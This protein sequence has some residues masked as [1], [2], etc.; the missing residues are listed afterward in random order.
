MSKRKIIFI[1]TALFAS[2]T[3]SAKND[4]NDLIY[5]IEEELILSEDPIIP[6]EIRINDPVWAS[7]PT[8]KDI[9]KESIKNVKRALDPKHLKNKSYSN[10]KKTLLKNSRM[11]KPIIIRNLYSDDINVDIYDKTLFSAFMPFNNE[12]KGLTAWQYYLIQKDRYNKENIVLSS[13]GFLSVSPKSFPGK[14]QIV[15]SN[16][17]V[18]EMIEKGL[19]IKLNKEPMAVGIRIKNKWKNYSYWFYY[20]FVDRGIRIND[21]LEVYG[22]LISPF[23]LVDDENYKPEDLWNAPA[24]HDQIIYNS[25]VF[26]IEDE[27]QLNLYDI[28]RTE[29][30]GNNIL[31]YEE[32]KKLIYSSL[33]QR[34][35]SLIII[36]YENY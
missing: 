4:D 33:G 34:L 23:A 20:V 12:N 15:I 27:Q 17:D 19:S 32:N 21:E 6:T 8:E 13:F 10:E 14:N 25:R 1:A 22:L 3:I 35:K 9:M 5:F 16:K 36:P 7:K 29:L 18:E 30:E 24:G 11:S 28:S 2:I 31:Y 26:Y